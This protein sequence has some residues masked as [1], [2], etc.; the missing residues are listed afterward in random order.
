M[1]KNATLRNR[2]NYLWATVG[3]V[4]TA[5]SGSRTWGDTKLNHID[6]TMKAIMR[7][8]KAPIRLQDEHYW[9]W[10]KRA[11]Q[12]SRDHLQAYVLKP[13]SVMIQQHQWGWSGHVARRAQEDLTKAVADWRPTTKGRPGRPR[14]SWLWNQPIEAHL[15]EHGER[16]QATAANRD[17]WKRKGCAW[18]SDEYDKRKVR[19]RGQ[20]QPPAVIE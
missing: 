3:A 8:I 20:S 13:W 12:T 10:K 5:N 14:A 17:S 4:I 19:R 15:R 16:W 6:S 1:N 9:D 11:A 7:R 2:F 18:V